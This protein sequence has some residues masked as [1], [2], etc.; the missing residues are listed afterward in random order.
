MHTYS[1]EGVNRASPKLEMILSHNR[2][3][4]ATGSASANAIQTVVKDL[5]SGLNDWMDV[6]LYLITLI[7]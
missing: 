7:I 5:V 3:V 2:E 1:I 4:T 6:F